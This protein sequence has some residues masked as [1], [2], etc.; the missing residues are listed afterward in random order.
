[1]RQVFLDKEASVVKNAIQQKLDENA[2]LVSVQYSFISSGTEAAT[3]ADGTSNSLF[4]YIPQK[5]KGVL[6]SLAH[7][8]SGTSV[9]EHF[10][11][12]LRALGHSCSG[13]VIAVGA[14]V[15]TL[16]SGDYVACAG[17][18][19]AQYAD[20]I[21][22][23]VNLTVL[24][25]D[26]L[27]LR[28]ASIVT[29]GSIALQGIRRAQLQ[30]GETVC[31]IGLGLIGQVTVQLAKAA[32]CTVIGIDI[33][34]DRI[35]L[36]K[37]MGADH[38][39]DATFENLQ[40]SIDFLTHHKGVDC[41]LITATGSSSGILQQAMELTRKKGKVVLV[42]DVGL[43]LER[44][45][46]YKKEIDLLISHSYGP[47]RYDYS[48][49]VEGQ[50]YPY[51]YVRWTEKRNMEAIINLIIQGKL[52]VDPLITKEHPVEDVLKASN[53]LKSRKSLGVVLSYAPKTELNFI[54]ARRQEFTEESL[55][56][57]PAKKGP[58]RVGIIGADELSNSHL[59]PTLSEIQDIKITAFTNC[60]LRAGETA[61]R[62]Y[63]AS[64]L[65]GDEQ[66]LFDD[67]AVDVVV[68]AS[69]GK[70]HC[71][72]AVDALRKGKAVFM[73]KPLARTSGQYQ[74][75]AD[76]LKN[77]PG[78][79]FCADYNKAF[80]PFI[81]KIK[82]ETA[83][84]CS[85]LMMSYRI[86]SGYKITKDWDGQEIRAGSIIE[87]ACHI[88]D[89]FCFLTSAKPVSVSVEAL[90]PVSDDIFPTDNFSAHISFD[91]GSLGSLVCSSI[92]HSGLGRERM[93]L[94]FDSKTIVMNDFLTLRG[95][96]V[97]HTFDETVT[98]PD[99][100]RS[101]LLSQFFE[102]IRKD[103][104]KMPIKM[105]RLSNVAQLT[106]VVDQLVCQGGGTHEFGQ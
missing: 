81:K 30:L 75:L 13:K 69:S 72:Q 97:S 53:D 71:D 25:P 8:E 73:E 67:K 45:P 40:Q 47:G 17:A 1:M 94:F 82:E 85:P 28:Q 4:S 60:Q 65:Y 26:P 20:M 100:G 74:K 44:D 62:L 105:D 70:F 43:H 54:P 106:L 24:I 7:K 48:Y 64:K 52:K 37:E 63:P 12:A 95:Y 19:F 21:C 39:F 42:G 88:F 5:I 15:T 58:L 59:L 90:R 76:F 66:E 9:K 35:V 31:V 23:P 93:E 41:T 61:S 78:V 92:G 101:H 84:R 27:F 2:V 6:S 98:V 11:G 68:I 99:K 46:F 80:A 49:E 10:K 83:G 51:G 3:L 86:N 103:S 96:G 32:G 34:A 104:W 79:P 87:E 57:V 22:V 38:V 14:K 77:N 18:D 16:R 36:A 102:E 29:L 33:L 50:D 89:L 91:D 55:Q 56:F